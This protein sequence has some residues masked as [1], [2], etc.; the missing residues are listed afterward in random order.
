MTES[1]IAIMANAV[2]QAIRAE[3]FKLGR[4]ILELLPLDL[5]ERDQV[6][7]LILQRMDELSEDIPSRE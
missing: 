6:K 4:E 2:R 5:P 1:M 3:V 7:A